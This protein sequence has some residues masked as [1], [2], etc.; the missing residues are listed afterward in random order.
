MLNL[1]LFSA[2]LHSAAWLASNHYT[3]VQLGPDLITS[4]N[5][6]NETFLLTLKLFSENKRRPFNL[7]DASPGF[8]Y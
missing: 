7:L 1:G 8:P 2:A 5:C 3:S 6:P 4:M